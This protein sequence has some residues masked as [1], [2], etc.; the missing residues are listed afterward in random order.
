M[1]HTVHI[2]EIQPASQLWKNNGCDFNIFCDAVHSCPNIFFS[3]LNDDFSK[4]YASLFTIFIFEMA[5]K[6]IQSRLHF[7]KCHFTIVM[8]EEQRKTN[9]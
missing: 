8:S 4:S 5:N 1:L 2:T 7:D 3:F 6:V 9:T